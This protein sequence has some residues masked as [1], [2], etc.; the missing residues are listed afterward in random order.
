MNKNKITLKCFG[1][2]RDILGSDIHQLDEQRLSVK[3]LRSLLNTKYHQMTQISGY[4]VAVNQTYASD[5]KMITS[6][7]EVAIIPPVSGG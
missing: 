4:M 2:V 6:Q 1:I 7:D 5:D 3:E